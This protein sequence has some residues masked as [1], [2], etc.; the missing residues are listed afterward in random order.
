M[1]DTLNTENRAKSATAEGA[2]QIGIVDDAGCSAGPQGD[3]SLY[4]ASGRFN[5]FRQSRHFEHRLLVATGRNDIGMRLM[6]NSLDG[7]A[8][9]AHDQTHYSV[10]HS[11]LN[12]YVTGHRR[13]W[14]GRRT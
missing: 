8:L 5:A 11:Y 12:R 3:V 14:S 1:I 10:R 6:L 9:R 7:R 4:F 13:G 2:Q